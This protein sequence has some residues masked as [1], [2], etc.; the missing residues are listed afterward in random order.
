MVVWCMLAPPR[1][2][3]SFL[4]SPSFH[5]LFRLRAVV[6]PIL[7]LV[8]VVSLLAQARL[9]LQEAQRDLLR[10]SQVGTSCAVRCQ[11]GG[12]GRVCRRRACVPVLTV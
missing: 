9:K 12:T 11:E 10:L 5:V 8:L 3:R 2:L 6:V 7:I 4:L 1:V